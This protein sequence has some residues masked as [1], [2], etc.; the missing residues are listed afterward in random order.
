MQTPR[1]AERPGVEADADLTHGNRQGSGGGNLR[2]GCQ[3]GTVDRD[4]G[5]GNNRY[6]WGKA[7]RIDNTI[8]GDHRSFP[9]SDVEGCRK[10]AGRGDIGIHSRVRAKRDSGTGKAIDVGEGIHI[11]KG[12]AP[13]HGSEPNGGVRDRD[14]VAVRDLRNHHAPG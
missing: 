6:A 7:G 5:T 12:T 2:G 14:T 11:A 9:G 13:S 4:V 1:E 3:I 8:C 10:S